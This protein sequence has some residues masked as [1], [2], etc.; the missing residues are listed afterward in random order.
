L[1][2]AA[3]GF[4]D[5]LWNSKGEQDRREFLLL[6]ANQYLP[7][8]ISSL[9]DFESTA[10]TLGN[11]SVIRTRASRNIVRVLVDTAMS[12]YAKTETRVQ[13]LTNA[14]TPGE[15]D[16]AEER[17]DAANALLE[18]TDSERELRKMALHG[19]LF[20]LGA[21]KI[22]D[23]GQG[24]AVEH[25]AAWELMYDPADAKRGK[26]TILV[27]RFAADR[28]ALAD[29]FAPEIEDDGTPEMAGK[30]LD[31]K[32]LRDEI[33][34]SGS[35][36]MIS[37]DH[38]PS[39]QHCAVYELWR[40]PVGDQKGRH[41]VVTDKALCLDEE[42]DSETF[43]FV[44]FGY[45]ENPVGPYPVSVA[46]IVSDLQ[47]E[48]NGLAER[49]M[50]ILRLMA[51]PI[52]VEHAAAATDGQSACTTVQLRGGSGAIGDI[53]QAPIGTTLERIP[54]GNILGTELSAEEDRAWTRGFQMA[55]MNEQSAIGSRPA[56]LN[57]APSQR[58]WNELQQDRLSLVAI[59]YQQ[60]HVDL[61]DR[62]L[63]CVAKLPDYEINVK[64]ANGKFLKKLRASD[65]DLENSD[66]VI[67][68]YPI[69]ALPSTP[70][71]KLAAAADLLQA[72]AID[73]DDFKQ[74]VQLPDLK[75]ELDID[76]ASR[77]ATQTIVGD[78]LAG[79]EFLSPLD[80]MDLAYAVKYGTAKL[81]T[82]I[83]ERWQSDRL[84]QLNDWIDAAAAML[85]KKTPAP[86]PAGPAPPTSI[87]PITP[88]PL[89]P[90]GVQG[91]AA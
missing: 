76:L 88:P 91:M 81:M 26:P 6:L 9:I 72:G 37:S 47:L 31:R 63:E 41:V 1:R 29:E 83:A 4:G 58:E 54:A 55:G 80:K 70:T 49:R 7:R 18:Q 84:S 66:Y 12:R 39:D 79:R 51:V 20:D 42:W 17:T 38:T 34:D 61:C 5:S 60:A 82:G 25:T 87:A 19:T 23:D 75:S 89:A 43:P 67:Q 50:Q 16:V 2:E 40:L 64:N 71:G 22:I 78:I 21:C 59:A 69:G 57:S 65:L 14:G 46:A 52:W 90:N 11:A 28:D 33:L 8:P 86:A 13:Y 35:A 53:V 15:Q 45:S 73:K 24:P 85:A 36:G 77:Q 10:G 30:I 32:N 48:I 74:I 68:R 27:Q 44:F 3:W 62:L 56:G